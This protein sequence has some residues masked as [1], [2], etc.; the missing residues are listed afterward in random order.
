[1][2]MGVLTR[3]WPRRLATQLGLLIVLA[4]FVAQAI[5]FTLL[6]RERRQFALEQITGPAATRFIDASERLAAGKPITAD[7][8][9]VRLMSVSPIRRGIMA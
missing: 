3:L 6:L 4:L 5:N 2:R 7:R 9:R 1:M 8:G